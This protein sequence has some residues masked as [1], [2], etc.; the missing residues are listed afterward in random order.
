MLGQTPAK[1]SRKTFNW[2]SKIIQFVPACIRRTALS[3]GV[4]ECKIGR[5]HIELFNLTYL[6][7]KI[8]SLNIL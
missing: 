3:S 1:V 7:Q 6:L 4:V 2:G 5:V 8:G